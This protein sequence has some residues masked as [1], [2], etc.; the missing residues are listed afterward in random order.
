MY[1]LTPFFSILAAISLFNS[2][3][4]LRADGLCAL[5]ENGRIRASIS[6]DFMGALG[7]RSEGSHRLRTLV[8]SRRSLVSRSR[9]AALC[10]KC[11][12]IKAI[13][14]NASNFESPSAISTCGH[15]RGFRLA[16]A[17]IQASRPDPELTR[18]RIRDLS[19]LREISA[20]RRVIEV[21]IV[22]FAQL[23]ASLFE[24]SVGLNRNADHPESSGGFNGSNR[25]RHFRSWLPSTSSG[26]SSPYHERKWMGRL[27][28]VSCLPW[29]RLQYVLRPSQS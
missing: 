22:A 7:S 23:E 17:L 21:Q 4:D 6:R 16:S 18:L 2:S 3:Q 15:G 13:D 20:T 27:D 12:C 29:K 26:Q 5:A 19:N 1:V 8:C 11:G 28:N 9:E 14:E 25:S 10:L 24:S